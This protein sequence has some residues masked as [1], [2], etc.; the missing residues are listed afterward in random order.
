MIRVIRGNQAKGVSPSSAIKK[1]A[2]AQPVKQEEPPKKKG[3]KKKD[4]SQ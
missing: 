1:E 2:I 3:R 4:A